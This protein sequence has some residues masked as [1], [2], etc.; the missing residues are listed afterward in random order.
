MSQLLGSYQPTPLVI[1]YTFAALEALILS[2]PAASCEAILGWWR[3]NADQP[4]AEIEYDQGGDE[5]EEL[6]GFYEVSALF[7]FLAFRT[8]HR[9]RRV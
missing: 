6:N 1:R 4:I 2:C 7:E 5:I 3:P 9:K 8:K